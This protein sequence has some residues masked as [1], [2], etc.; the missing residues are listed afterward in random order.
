MHL[1]EEINNG[2]IMGLVDTSAFMSVMAVNI[3]RELGTMH[4]VLGHETY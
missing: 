1:H 2:V 3:V 4:L